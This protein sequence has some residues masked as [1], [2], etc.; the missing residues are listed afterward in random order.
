MRFSIHLAGCLSA[1][2]PGVHG[3]QPVVAEHGAGELLE[4]AEAV[5]VEG[6]AG[7]GELE[8]LL[9]QR[10]DDLGVAVAL[11]ELWSNALTL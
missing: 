6:A 5:V 4:L 1:L 11:R 7:E 8:G 2:H 10:R 3:Q 9:V